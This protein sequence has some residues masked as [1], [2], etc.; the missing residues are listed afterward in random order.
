MTNQFIEINEQLNRILN[1]RA[2]MYKSN[3]PTFDDFY[4]YV[5]KNPK[6]KNAIFK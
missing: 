3:Q 1:E 2:A 4:N 5:I 6:C